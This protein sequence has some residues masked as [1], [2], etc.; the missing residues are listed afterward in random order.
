GGVLL[1]R[2][3]EVLKNAIDRPGQAAR[4]VG[5]E[6][7]VRVPRCDE[8]ASRRVLGDIHSLIERNNHYCGCIPLSVSAGEATCRDPAAL[9]QALKDADH[10][11]YEDKRRYYS[12][13]ERRQGSAGR[14]E[15]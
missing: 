9:E 3:D 14:A 1:R 4:I 5:A 12:T 6:S 10:A 13:H 8:A 7:V 15:S 2:I 11:L